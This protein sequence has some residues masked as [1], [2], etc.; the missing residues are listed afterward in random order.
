MKVDEL[1]AKSR[2][3]LTVIT[4]LDYLVSA[5]RGNQNPRR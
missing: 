3:A 4:G 5:I 2:D 1:L